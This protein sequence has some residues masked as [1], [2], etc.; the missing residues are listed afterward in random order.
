[1][2]KGI[3]K[4]VRVRGKV[5]M[6][7]EWWKPEFQ[8]EDSTGENDFKVTLEKGGRKEYFCRI[9]RVGGNDYGFNFWG[10]SFDDTKIGP[11]EE[12]KSEDDL[13]S[14]FLYTLNRKDQIEV[15]SFSN[16]YPAFTG[17][18]SRLVDGNVLEIK[19]FIPYYNEKIGLTGP[20]ADTKFFEVVQSPFTQSVPPFPD[21]YFKIWNDWNSDYKKWKEDVEKAKKTQPD[22]KPAEELGKDDGNTKEST[23]ISKS[24]IFN[25]Q[26]ENI[27]KSKDFGTFSLVGLGEVEGDYVYIEEEKLLDEEYGEADFQGS[28][29]QLLSEAET[30]EVE[31]FANADSGRVSEDQK[32]ADEKSKQVEQNGSQNEDEN[33]FIQ[34]KSSSSYTIKG[35]MPVESSK[36]NDGGKVQSG[37]NGVPYYGQWDSRWA[38]V[39]YGWVSSGGKKLF[40]EELLPDTAVSEGKSKAAKKV[41][42]DDP[43]RFKAKIGGSEYD[44]SAWIDTGGGNYGWSSVQGGGC[45]ITSLAM[46]MNYWEKVNKTARW[47][48]PMKT[49]KIAVE[50]GFRDKSGVEGGVPPAK[51]RKSVNAPSGSALGSSGGRKFLK[52]EFGFD[53]LSIKK[54]EIDKYLNKKW[55]I[56]LCISPSPG[57]TGRTS[58]GKSTTYESGHFM[59]ITGIDTVSADY[60]V[61]Q[62]VGTKIYRI[63]DPGRSKGPTYMTEDDMKNATI[64]SFTLFYPSNLSV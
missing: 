12:Y 47:V 22:P 10:I 17:G 49:A 64:S 34:N 8:K 19:N 41:D 60:G 29:E 61:S 62:P 63:N 55:P 11:N 18:L 51:W 23:D 3:I 35:A 40:L 16:P 44:F 32:K 4:E 33:V 6:K 28:Q 39:L 45:G 13:I 36:S 21:G 38:K 27:L 43:V 15:N 54:N 9:D 53:Y 58:S 2:T 31:A 20:A 52:D 37:F 26:I 30:K 14:R 1:M 5:S 42:P 50:Y 25:V 59:V 56:I 46:V 7:G 24:Y 57:L 48:S